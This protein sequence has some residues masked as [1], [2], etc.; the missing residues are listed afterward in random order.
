MKRYP[1]PQLNVQSSEITNTIPKRNDDETDI[2]GREIALKKSCSSCIS[3]ELLILLL[4]AYLI[5]NCFLMS[6]F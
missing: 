3:S 4:Y 2:L 1:I 5:A 6:T